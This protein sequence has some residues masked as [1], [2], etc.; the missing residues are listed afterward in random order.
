M[1]EYAPVYTSAEPYSLNASAAI[2]GGRL[3]EITTAASVGPAA[4]G[5]TKVAGVAAHDAAINTKVL[6][7]PLLNSTHEIDSAGPIAVGDGVQAGAGGTIATG[8]SGTLAAAGSLLGI[9]DT[10]AGAGGV[11]TRF[12]SCQQAI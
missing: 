10:A 6:I 8:L 11:K 3:V 7:W 9:A 1:A 5:S 2:T 12:T 4:A